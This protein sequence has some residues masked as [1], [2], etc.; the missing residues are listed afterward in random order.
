MELNVQDLGTA[1]PPQHG[2]LHLEQVG[3]S[4]QGH[5]APSEADLR[6][7]R[8]SDFRMGVRYGLCLSKSSNCA[9]L[10]EPAI[11]DFSPKLV[12]PAL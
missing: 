9:T 6:G 2:T 1:F 8:F 12:S 10:E 5:W 4:R 3:W 11:S 7:W